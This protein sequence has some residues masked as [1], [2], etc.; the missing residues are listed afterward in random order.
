MASLGGLTSL[1]SL[2]MNGC[3]GDATELQAAIWKA[4]TARKVSLD[5]EV[6]TPTSDTT[7]D[8]AK[9]RAAQVKRLHA[10]AEKLRQMARELLD[11]AK[12]LEAEAQR[13]AD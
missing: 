10:E 4:I 8:T 12:R 13:L 2:D 3:N 9:A 6:Q 11:Q 5:P 1:K 7:S